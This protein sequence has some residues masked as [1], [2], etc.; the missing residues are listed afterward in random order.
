MT[1]NGIPPKE[2]HPRT[3][4]VRA[5]PEYAQLA[6]VVRSKWREQQTTGYGYSMKIHGNN[7][8]HLDQEYIC[9]PYGGIS[10]ELSYKNI[11]R[12]LQMRSGA[13]AS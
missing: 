10:T 12:A 13:I 5:L 11:P 6:A 7:T 9:G 3:V 1:E 2:G 8:A 4:L